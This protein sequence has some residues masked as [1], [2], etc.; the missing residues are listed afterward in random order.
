MY[1]LFNNGIT[2]DEAIQFLEGLGLTDSHFG[3]TK[4]NALGVCTSSVTNNYTLLW[5]SMLS[6]N[7][8]VSW[9]TQRHLCKSF[10]EFK[11][12]V[13]AQHEWYLEHKGKL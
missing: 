10:E 6:N 9:I 13:I 8:H 1:I 3:P 7:P 11:E 2:A 12:G 4:Q 5:G